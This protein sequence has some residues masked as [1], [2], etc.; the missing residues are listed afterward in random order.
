ML[1]LSAAV[2]VGPS[3][4]DGIDSDRNAPPEATLGDDIYG[5]LCDRL[6]ASV[7]REDLIGASYHDIC[8]FDAQGQYGFTVDT[9][10]LPPVSGEQAVRARTLSIAK[11]HRMAQ[12]RADLVAAFNIVFPDVIVPDV[13]TDAPDDTVRLHDALLEFSQ[14]ITALYEDNPFE[15]G[16]DP[17]MVMATDA[18][19]R[20]FQALQDS[21]E[22]RGALM[23]IAGRRG[24]RPYQAGLGA[25]RTLL[26][27]PDMRPLINAQLEVL[28]AGGTAS[29]ELQKLLEVT[30]LELLSAVASVAQLPPLTID[31]AQAQPSRPRSATEVGVRLLLDE[32]PDYLGLAADLPRYIAKR[33]RRGFVLPVGNTPGILGTVST[34]FVDVDS[35]GLADV[36]G[37]GRFIGMDGLVLTIDAPFS[38]PGVATSPADA[39]GRPF[40]SPYQYIDTSRTMLAA[41]L[42]DTLPL[43]DPQKYAN[44]GD[45]Q[46]WMS[47]YE[48]LMYALSGL[49]LLSGPRQAA[50]FDHT[51][52]AILPAGQSCPISDVPNPVTGAVLPCTQ[53]QR[54]VAEQ[55]PIPD[56]IHGV[57]QILAHPDSDL[58]LLGLL[59]LID[60]H[61]PVMARLIGAALKAKDIA[62]A[63][64]DLAL[65]GLEPRA[66]L[67]YEVPVWDEMAQ[68]L[69]Q[70]AQRDGLLAALVDAMADPVVI[71]SHT[72]DPAITGPPAAHMGETLAAFMRFRD[73]YSYD[74]NDINGPAYNVTDGY[75]SFANPH[76]A[77]DRTEP[78]TGDNRSMFE[79]AAQLIYDGN[80]VKACNKDG[81]KVYSGV[82]NI[83]VPAFSSYQEC[84]LFVFPNVGAY[85]LDANLPSNHPKRSELVIQNAGL[86]D[87][88][89]FLGTL[90][91]LDAFMESASGIDG[92]TLH[93]TP[94]ALARLMFYGSGSEQWGQLP[95]YDS[96]NTGSNVDKFVSASI[97]PICGIVSPINGNGVNKCQVASD[98]L[99]VRDR[100]TM[101]SWE[102]LGFYQ[103]LAPQLR[104]FA[105]V[106]CDATGTICDT[107]DFTG[108]NFFL[109]LV[110][111]L[112][113][114]W[115]GPDHGPSCSSTVTK[116]DPTYCSGAG[117]NRYEPILAEV[118]E[119]DLVSAIHAFATAAASVN[120]TYQ[121]GPKRGQTINGTEIVELLVKILFD[122]QY[123]ASS[124][125]RDRE[126]NM[127]AAWVD[128]TAQAQVTPFMV[129]ADALRAMDLSFDDSADATAVERKS[130]WRRARSQ[131]VD[132][133]LATEGEGPTTRFANPGIAR[134]LAN[135]L[136]V[137]REQLN[138]NCPAR[139]SGTP[140]T[141]ASQQ[142]GQKMNDVLGRPVFSAISAVVD[143]LNAHDGARRGL[144]RF[145]S[146]GLSEAGPEA[147]TSVLASVSDLL[148]VVRA[149]GDLSPILR[150][151]SVAANPRSDPAGPGAADRTLQLLEAMGGDA[152][153]RYHVL[154]YV[155]PALVTPMNGGAGVTPLEVIVDALADIH[156]VDAALA[157]PLDAED[158]KYVMSTL[159]EF[160]V[161]EERGLRQLYYIV[162]NRPTE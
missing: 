44:E 38:I 119:G 96:V 130:R 5:M 1:A 112:W 47:E 57:G 114:H 101:F 139:E 12:R 65:Q 25:I 129:L 52:D 76:N 60:N 45:E 123:A 28:G 62:N 42:R 10:Q 156:R 68:V 118:L 39:F 87:L 72:Q 144:E 14:D 30:K 100:Y 11:M 153:D 80:R 2:A 145:L 107:A 122:Q 51:A 48:T 56:L 37:L 21:E 9:G 159:R 110:T 134:V 126:G 160:L 71:Q 117:L 161:S 58:I 116:S 162:Q 146:Y 128:G 158:Y 31:A 147:L 154:D 108:E 66:V 6:G 53:Y 125:M 92:F 149:D 23:R 32:H 22:A 99:R 102:R 106:S 111:T 43:L 55:S 90:T 69:S 46:P 103:Y 98:T 150:A 141:W 79:R 19:G 104:A 151:V 50:Q 138:A 63:H 61:R 24:Y 105:E 148:Q 91:N 64:D 40:D 7:F 131:L 4:N 41:I 137:T 97:E 75:P 16:A 120:I 113:R 142:L 81:A 8:H 115:P 155:L 82:G 132:Q 94:Q 133:F 152:Y 15:Q 109:D 78:Q 29:Q 20:F 124:G 35:D 136:Q 74:P 73:I 34:P 93:P 83:Y 95:D 77:V 67:P 127:S 143:K 36:D 13:T 49:H 3:C 59:E 140:C 27:Y 84:G 33:D 135:L 26:G 157:I 89:V 85:F 18:L 70:M 88:L 54:F 121:R 17:T 86:Q